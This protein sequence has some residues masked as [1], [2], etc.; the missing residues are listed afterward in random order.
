MPLVDTFTTARL[1]ADRLRPGDLDDLLR[2][3]AD[4][5]TMATLSGVYSPKSTAEFLKRNLE[6]WEKHGFGLWALRLR[7]DG[8][9]VG[10]AGLRHVDVAG[11]GEIE[12]SYAL[13]AE[14][15]G[16]G[17][18]TE[19]ARALVDLAFDQLGLVDLVSFTL[20]TNVGSRRVMEKAGFR[21]EADIVN[22]GLAHVLYRR[23]RDE[24]FTN[25]KRQRGSE[26]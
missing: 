25:P 19:A 6:H 12:L 23:R 22:A 24:E 2:M 8:R 21:F 7:T 4:P 3:H 15:W 26:E 16:Q 11:K 9:F 14:F 1:R 20:P 10:R 13:P 5:R 17:L 18:A